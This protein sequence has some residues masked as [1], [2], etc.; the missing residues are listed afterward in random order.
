MKDQKEKL[1]KRFHLPSHRNKILRTKLPKEAKDLYSEN[2]KTVLKEIEYKTN[3]ME[4]YAMFLD[5]KKQYHQNDYTDE[6]NQRLHKYRK[7]YHALVLEESTL[8]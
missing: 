5:W 1:R 7:I 8:S 2:Y 4:K 6:E 3:N